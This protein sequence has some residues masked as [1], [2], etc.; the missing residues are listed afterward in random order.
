VLRGIFE[1]KRDEVSEGLRKW[2]N[3]KLQNLYSSPNIGMIKAR[4][5]L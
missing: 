5:I 1:P 3:E 2:H 4:R